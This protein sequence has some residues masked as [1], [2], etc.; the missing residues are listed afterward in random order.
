M[1]VVLKNLINFSVLEAVRRA[2]EECPRI[3]AK[4]ARWARR[5]LSPNTARP[6]AFWGWADLGFSISGNQVYN[7]PH[8]TAVSVAK[9]TFYEWLV[10]NPRLKDHLLWHT[11]EKEEAIGWFKDGA[12]SVYCRALSRGKSGAGITVAHSP[13]E[14]VDSVY[15]TK[16]V[17]ISTEF[18]VHFFTLNDLTLVTQKLKLGKSA[19]EDRGSSFNREIRTHDNGWVYGQP[20]DKLP[21]DSAH[22]AR[23]LAL[24]IGHEIG[25]TYG[26][27]DFIHDSEGNKVWIVEANSAPGVSG[28]SA[29]EFYSNVFKE[30]YNHA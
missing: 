28:E 20:N 11:M 18:R 7:P 4:T 10:G 6:V 2:K 13:E 22:V 9:L 26:C 23:G 27:V 8:A 25:L 24:E 19:R 14:V 15:Y 17:Q 5:N 21:E 16:G 29:T 30:I 12:K 1:L 3:D